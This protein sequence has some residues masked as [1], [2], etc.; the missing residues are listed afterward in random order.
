MELILLSVFGIAMLFLLE[1]CC[2]F[3]DR[4][5]S[6]NYLDRFDLR[7]APPVSRMDH[8]SLSEYLSC[9]TAANDADV[10]TI[11]LARAHHNSPGE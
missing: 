11:V 5:A 3:F 1:F 2:A 6:E 8:L 10:T 9:S 4:K 7:A